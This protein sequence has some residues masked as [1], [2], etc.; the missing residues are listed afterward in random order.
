[1]MN[2]LELY[3]SKTDSIPILGNT[4]MDDYP[5]NVILNSEGEDIHSLIDSFAIIFWRN[6]SDGT[7]VTSINFSPPILTYVEDRLSVGMTKIHRHDYIEMAFVV[8]GEFSQVVGGQRVTFPQGSVCI[9]D[10]NTEHADY[11]KDQDNFVIFICMKENFFDEIL[12]TEIENNNVQQFIRKALLDQKSLKQLLQFTPRGQ[13]DVLLPLIE[14]VCD[15]KCRNQ[16]G[17]N[18]I[19]KGL[20][21]RIFFI[22]TMHYDIS[23]T[24]TQKK[25]LND[26][27]FL[28]VEEYLRKNY[29]EA[30]LKELISRFHFQQDYFARLI[31]KH[32]GLT[33]S[34]YLRKIRISKAE[35]LLLNTRMTTTQII[36]S[37][38]YKNRNHFYNVFH[39]IHS[40]TPEQFRQN[41][42]S[43]K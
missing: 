21:V 20:M 28:E 19:V 22:L 40:M 4:I 18:Y 15:E 35:E 13:H 23:L 7:V 24:E 25:H 6:I 33:F 36:D 32:T 14:Q 39:S 11:V 12:L 26:L 37:I 41:M 43:K 38:G 17:A 3:F 30:S 31:K 10:R 2:L 42:S 34:E 8:K 16:K 1:M 29:Q 5:L 27:L 9:I